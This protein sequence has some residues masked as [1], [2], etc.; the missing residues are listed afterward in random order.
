MKKFLVIGAIF[1]LLGC[2]PEQTVTPGEK[3]QTYT[4]GIEIA[5]IH[6]TTDSRQAS[7]S[8]KDTISMAIGESTFIYVRA[9]SKDGRWFEL[10]SD[11]TV[12][13]NCDPELEVRPKTGPIV[14]VKVIKPVCVVSFINAFV[15]TGEGKKIDKLFRVYPK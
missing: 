15:T 7:G 6:L 2:A 1:I 14:V 12:E 9:I 10:P 8:P 4:S 3:V 5:G 13:W 11:A